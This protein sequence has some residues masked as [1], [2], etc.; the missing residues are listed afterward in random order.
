VASAVTITTGIAQHFDVAAIYPLD[1]IADAVRHVSEPDKIG[2]V[3][4]RP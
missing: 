2:T 1:R 4:V 3:V